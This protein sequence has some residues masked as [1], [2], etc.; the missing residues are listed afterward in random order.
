MLRACN[1]S[2]TIH[3]CTACRDGWLV[4]SGNLGFRKGSAKRSKHEEA[5][6]QP[7]FKGMLKRRGR[8]EQLPS[9]KDQEEEEKSE[10]KDKGVG[11]QEE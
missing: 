5:I 9:A 4:R 3:S 8:P 7:K 2:A 6:P 1:T 10:G 11:M